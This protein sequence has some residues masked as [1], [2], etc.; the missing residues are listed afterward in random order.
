MVRRQFIQCLTFAGTGAGIA[1]IATAHANQNKMVT[2]QVSGF[3]CPTCAV[4]LDTMLRQQ[5][6][7]VRS[8]SNYAHATTVV[9]FDPKLT[10]DQ[11]IKAFIQEM[12]FVAEAR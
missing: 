9:E 7:V 2:Y 5:K 11:S 4:G 6:G 10:T 12:G 1:A 8:E 3:S